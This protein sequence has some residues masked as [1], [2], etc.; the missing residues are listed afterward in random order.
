M[1]KIGRGF[2]KLLVLCLILLLF[3]Q[4]AYAQNAELNK[5]F[6]EFRIEIKYIFSGVSALALLTSI[7]IFI[8]H[9][10]RLALHANHPYFRGEIIKNLLISG[11]CTA[12]LGAVNTIVFIAFTTAH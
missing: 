8:I 11:I 5:A 6:G 9:F 7:V 4:V 2:K 3:T 10:I 1:M 12:L